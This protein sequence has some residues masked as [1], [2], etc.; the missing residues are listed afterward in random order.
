ME[1]KKSK[2]FIDGGD[3]TRILSDPNN[4][5]SDLWFSAVDNHAYLSKE[6]CEGKQNLIVLNVT[7]M[8]HLASLLINHLHNINI[9]NG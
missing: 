8:F 2:D 4:P 6:D 1:N 3:I 5:T 9:K 7:D